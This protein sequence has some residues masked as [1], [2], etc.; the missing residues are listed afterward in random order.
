M[1]SNVKVF[2]NK[3]VLNHCAP[4]LYMYVYRDDLFKKWREIFFCLKGVSRDFQPLTF[5]I[6]QYIGTLVVIFANIVW[7][8]F[9]CQVEIHICMYRN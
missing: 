6:H 3:K 5:S 2:E 4:M 8:L 7:K 1:N 9:K